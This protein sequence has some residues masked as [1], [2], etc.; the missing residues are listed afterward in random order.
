M[1]TWLRLAMDQVVNNRS[2]NGATFL[3]DM[4]VSVVGSEFAI[5]EH[6]GTVDQSV[7]ATFWR[8][9]VLVRVEK[10]SW[11]LFDEIRSRRLASYTHNGPDGVVAK[12]GNVF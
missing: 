5:A 8:R 2:Y 11:K 12:L 1:S 4:K 6:H 3:N 7:E 10:D 9:R